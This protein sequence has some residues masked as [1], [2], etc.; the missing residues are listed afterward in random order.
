MGPPNLAHGPQAS[1]A[2]ITIVGT[3]AAGF[4]DLGGGAFTPTSPSAITSPRLIPMRNLMRRSLG[5][6]A[7]RSVIPR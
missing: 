4:G 3:Q 6:A 1:E 2:R 7:S 5:I